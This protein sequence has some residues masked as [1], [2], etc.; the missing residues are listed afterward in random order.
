M[1]R[2]LYTAVSGMIAQ[3]AKQ[4]VISNNLANAETTGFKTDNLAIK[5]FD[6]VLLANHDKI[7]NG[8]SQENVIGSLSFGSQVDGTD[9]A[10]TQGDL[11]ETDKP[12]DFAINGRGFFTVGRQDQVAGLQ[13][14]YTRDG[15]FHVDNKGYL[16]TDNGDY[17]MGKNLSTNKVEPIKVNNSKLDLNPSN[18]VL[19]DGKPSYKLQLADF[20]NYSDLK[21]A[22]DNL[23]NGAAPNN[24]QDITV[25]QGSLEKSNVNVTNEMINM[26]TVVR[27]YESDQKVIASIDE[28]LD[29]VVNDVGN[30]R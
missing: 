2:G 11:Q 13:N 27:S 28:T 7:E 23:F 8:K 26:M 12:T 24:N 19:I 1:I 9:T 21:K 17:V 5:K 15:H 25:K 4:D 16:A 30:V 6:D 14:Y 18:I 20:D 10:F 3:E 29:K 22:G